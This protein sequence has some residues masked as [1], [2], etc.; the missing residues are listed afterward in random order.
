VRHVPDCGV[1]RERKMFVLSR[2]RDGNPKAWCDPCIAGLVTALNA[3]GLRTIASCCGHGHRPGRV[4]LFDG[5]ELYIATP[6]QAEVIEAA[7]PVDINGEV[8]P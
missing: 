4:T 7:F 3:A 5:T 2:D 1:D 8:R 6:A